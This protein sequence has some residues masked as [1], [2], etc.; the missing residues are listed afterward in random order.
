MLFSPFSPQ[1]DIIV[2]ASISITNNI[3]NYL[4]RDEFLWH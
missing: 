4:L 1:I 3:K 2:I